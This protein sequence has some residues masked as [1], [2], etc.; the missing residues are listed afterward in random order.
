MCSS[1]LWNHLRLELRGA[2]FRLF[3]N[4]ELRIERE[5]L[6]FIRPQGRIALPAYT[7]GSGQCTV[8]YDNVVVTALE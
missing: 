2:A 1:D 5:A 6:K 7:G 8:Y 3:V 4:G